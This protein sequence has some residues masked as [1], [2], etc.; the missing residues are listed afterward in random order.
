[1]NYT[2]KAA[3]LGGSKISGED[4]RDQNGQQILRMI[5]CR[6]GLTVPQ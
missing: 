3:V 2:D 5:V 6:H 4:I 1:L